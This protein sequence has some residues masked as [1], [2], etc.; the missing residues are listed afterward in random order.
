MSIS[1]P[2]IVLD[3]T[4]VSLGT[5][6]LVV[7]GNAG[8]LYMIPT[9]TLQQPAA[10]A[11]FTV[12]LQT[13]TGIMSENDFVVA[14][15]SLS[16]GGP[17][18]TFNGQV[19]KAVNSGI[20]L[21]GSTVL[22]TSLPSTPA[23]DPQGIVGTAGSQVFTALASGS[24]IIVGSV[25]LSAGGQAVMFNGDLINIA[26]SRIVIGGSTI[27]ISFLPTSVSPVK[28][29]FTLG[30]IITIGSLSLSIHGPVATVSGKVV[31]LGPNNIM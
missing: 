8:N 5:N 25:T 19:I 13:F 15:S 20:L 3:N 11:I 6:R 10:G 7:G 2:I 26:G 21:G 29:I 16:I 23:V 27:S 28:A 12:S 9:P 18:A 14:G 17:A 4:P 1:G 30:H 22:I 31:S 24:N